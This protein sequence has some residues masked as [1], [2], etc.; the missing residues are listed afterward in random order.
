LKARGILSGG[1]PCGTLGDVKTVYVETSIPSYLTARRSV[2][3]RVVACQQFT[4]QWW[5]QARQRYELYISELVVAEASEGHAEAVQRRLDAMRG[6]P[7]LPVDRRAE[8]LAAKLVS[9][10][11]FPP[12][13][14]A[15]AL[16]VAIAAVHSMDLLLTWNC[17]HINNPETKPVM[18]SIC[19]VAG[20][21]CPEI[22]TPQ[23]LLPEDTRDVP[24]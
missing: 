17:R 19:A 12:A 6:L 4:V 14:G 22:C 2:D 11:G 24:G 9:D 18:R 5:E 20:H 21:T 1:T 8:E 23:E 10:G 3:L 16:H 7:E 13:A 15:D